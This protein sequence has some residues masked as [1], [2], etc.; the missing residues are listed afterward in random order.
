MKKNLVFLNLLAVGLVSV[1]VLSG[2]GDAEKDKSSSSA[3]SSTANGSEMEQEFRDIT[4]GTL[5][6][7]GTDPLTFR[8]ADDSDFSLE[9]FDAMDPVGY[10]GQTDAGEDQGSYG[11]ILENDV[12][13]S[14]A[15]YEKKVDAVWE[16]WESLGLQ[17]SNFSPADNARSI[18]AQTALGGEVTYMAS[19]HGEYVTSDSACSV[20]I[21]V[22][23]NGNW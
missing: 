19:E 17:P 9:K 3:S 6:A 10:C 15:E 16:Y 18:R 4:K 11:V 8:L 5:K 2:C 7:A 13:Y 21:V 20:K 12:N 22:P 1:N 14:A 23:D